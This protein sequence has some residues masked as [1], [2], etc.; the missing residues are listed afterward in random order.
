MTPNSYRTSQTC[1]SC[2]EIIGEFARKLLS[3]NPGQTGHLTEASQHVNDCVPCGWATLDIAAFMSARSVRQM[4]DRWASPHLVLSMPQLEGLRE[5]WHL[6]L[7]AA[8]LVKD[9]RATARGLSVLGLIERGLDDTSDEAIRLHE[10]ALRKEEKS[11]DMRSAFISHADLAYIASWRPLPDY[12]KGVDHLELALELART[13]GDKEGERRL[14]PLMRGTAAAPGSRVTFLVKDMVAALDELRQTMVNTGSWQLL[15]PDL[16]K[17]LEQFAHQALGFHQLKP[18][19]A[20]FYESWLTESYQLA[21]GGQAIPIVG[22][23]A[24]L[25][26]VDE[27]MPRVDG[28]GFLFVSIKVD[29]SEL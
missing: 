10:L 17:N 1:Q 11:G 29:P 24:G 28:A 8:Q 27:L 13:L 3:E 16:L 22:S 5:L 23:A 26:V 4:M 12:V 21:T 15:E 9:D 2:R 25:R 18:A 14:Q 19:L 6:Q 20:A 7:G